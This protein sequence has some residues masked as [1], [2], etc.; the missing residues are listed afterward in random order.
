MKQFPIVKTV[1]S[2]AV[3]LAVW[4]GYTVPVMAE[5]L[6]LEEV[7]VTA[8]KREESL[9]ETPISVMAFGSDALEQQDITNLEG[10]DIKMPNVGIGGSG[11]LGGSNAS[12]YIRGIGTS[13]NAVN[14]ESSVALY[15]DD[16]YFGRSDGALLSVMDV[17]SIEV[18]RGPQGTLFGRSAT[19]G[20]I[21][22]ITKKPTEEF[23]GNLQATL[24]SENRRD[25]KGVVNI[26]L[27]DDLAL[28]LAGAT[29]NQDGHVDSAFSNKN[30]SDVN[31]DM[32]RA[33]L[34]WNASDT[35]EVLATLDYTKMDNNGGASILLGVNP[36]APFVTREASA[37]FDARLLPT[38]D[39]DTSYQ[40][41]ENFYDSENVGGN[42]TINWDISENLAFKASTSWRDI[43]ISGAY[44]ADGTNASLF[45]QVFEREIETFSQELQLSGVSLDDRLNWVAGIFYYEEEATDDRLVASTVNHGAPTSSTRI[46]DPAETESLAVF[47][48]GTYD[49]NEAWSVTLGLRYTKD[50]KD[51]DSTELNAFG[52]EKVPGGAQNSDEWSAVSGRLS[53][54]WQAMDD[55]F[56][57]TSFARGFRSG[58]F[59]DRIRTDLPND[60]FGIT[61]F[62]EETL[63]MYEIG[64]R[65]EL[66]EGRVRFNLTAFY[67]EYTDQQLAAVI[68]GSTRNVIQNAGESHIQ[69]LEGEFVVALTDIL[70]LDGTFGLLD[71]EYDEL[72]P[73]VTGVTLDSEFGRA[74][75]VS[76]SLGLQAD[77]G[78][79]VVRVDYGWVNDFYLTSA[80]T[81]AIEQEDYGLLSANISYIP[82]G[83]NWSISV[84]GNNLTDEEY[85]SGGLDF[86]GAAPSGIAQAEPGRFR[87]L[88]VKFKWE[89]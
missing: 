69:G 10:L 68:P 4:G 35:V 78:D 85:L 2:T 56:L 89:F 28:R 70:T 59:N 84:F 73:S 51:I 82:E 74:P 62:D 47:G 67:G 20:A 60:N 48:Q 57:F 44:D 75:E 21:R 11:G 5:G 32:A 79:V 12:F 14:Q 63:D 55:I 88:G 37:G 1:A 83:E 13:R 61:T 30:F 81:V 65:S 52:A 36:N 24:G 8:R 9:Q 64:M 39:F 54:E 72:D 41:G 80:A 45:E 19:S 3:L 16:A 27:S 53:L 77:F 50:E 42:L 66:W 40:T 33:K 6:T 17:Q 23:E 26:P 7:V 43:D 34:L 18:L 87:E 25:L 38:G 29:L 58:G 15:V 46:I 31:S 76:Y 49:L 86:R 22:Y 71:T